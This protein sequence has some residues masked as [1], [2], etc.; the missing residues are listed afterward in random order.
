MIHSRMSWLIMIITI[1][2]S[3]E[4]IGM[5]LNTKV[6]AT[7]IAGG[8]PITVGIKIINHRRPGSHKIHRDLTSTKIPY[9]RSSILSNKMLI[10]KINW[11]KSKSHWPSISRFRIPYL[12]PIQPRRAY[13]LMS[14]KT[15]FLRKIR[16]RRR[17]WPRTDP[18]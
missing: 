4:A 16:N 18:K 2:R 15:A 6:K 12:R 5:G 10:S 3:E 9:K 11:S 17:S 8:A 14:L 7:M 1:H 13:N